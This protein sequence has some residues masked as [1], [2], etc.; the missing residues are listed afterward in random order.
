MRRGVRTTTE[1]DRSTYISYLDLPNTRN[2]L[3]LEA[4]ARRLAEAPDEDP[5]IEIEL[6]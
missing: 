2:Y 5:P 6:D 4:A 3:R 1:C